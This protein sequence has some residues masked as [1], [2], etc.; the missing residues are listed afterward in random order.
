LKKEKEKGST[1]NKEGRGKRGRERKKAILLIE[2][3]A[4]KKERGKVQV[5]HRGERRGGEKKKFFL[6]R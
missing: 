1:D 6:H 3:R 4:E 5:R 2:M